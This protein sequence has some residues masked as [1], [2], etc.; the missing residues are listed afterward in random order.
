MQRSSFSVTVELGTTRWTAVHISSIVRGVTPQRAASL[1]H[2]ETVLAAGTD[3][4]LELMAVSLQWVV[5][6]VHLNLLDLFLF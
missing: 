3:D 2:M 4:E 5:A 1:K 6:F